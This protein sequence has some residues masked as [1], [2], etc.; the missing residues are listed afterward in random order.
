M[1]TKAMFIFVFQPPPVLSAAVDMLASEQYDWLI[2]FKWLCT[3]KCDW[4]SQ[5]LRHP[6]PSHPELLRSLED[7]LRSFWEYVS[8]LIFQPS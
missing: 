5:L 3:M 8:E 7:V 4:V 2:Y 1:G 6:C